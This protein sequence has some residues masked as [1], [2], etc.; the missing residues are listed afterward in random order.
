M[1]TSY[2]EIFKKFK[3][4]ISDVELAKL[5]TREQDEQLCLWL[6]TAIGLIELDDLKIQNDL[7]DRDNDLGEFTADLTNGEMEVV[8]LYMVVAWY[9]QKINSMEH[10]MLYIGTKDEKW[11]NQR[12]HLRTMN[13]TCEMYRLRARKYFRNYCYK[14]N[15]YLGDE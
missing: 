12:E 6:D 11:T 15:N 5:S 4:K 7:S 10:I 3:N 9:D 1:A 14:N 2:E 8:S 13:D